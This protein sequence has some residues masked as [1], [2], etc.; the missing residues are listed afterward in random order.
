MGNSRKGG[1]VDH[2]SL[3]ELRYCFYLVVLSLW[4]VG[5]STPV[6]WVW[7]QHGNEEK[8]GNGT[9]PGKLNIIKTNKDTLLTQP[10][11]A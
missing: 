8:M 6:V 3:P 7:D 9:K 1:A 2:R 10:S 4:S 11:V 5:R